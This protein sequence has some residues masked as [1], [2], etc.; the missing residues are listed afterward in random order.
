MGSSP[1]EKGE[2]TIVVQPELELTDPTMGESKERIETVRPWS[3]TSSNPDSL[4]EPQYDFESEEF[5]RIPDL[6][7]AVVSFKDD[8]TLHVIT[9]RSVVLSCIFCIIGSFVSQ[10]S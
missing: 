3:T 1:V 4:E 6:V 9:F 7:R 5:A 2:P 10:L 8:P